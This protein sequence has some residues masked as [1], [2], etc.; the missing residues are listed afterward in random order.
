MDGN[1]SDSNEEYLVQSMK[2]EIP[3]NMQILKKVKKD[4]SHI[5]ETI[6]KLQ[7]KKDF[8]KM[9]EVKQKI[10][11][12]DSIL[13]NFEELATQNKLNIVQWNALKKLCKRDKELNEIEGNLKVL[14]QYF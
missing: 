1:V 7:K 8:N 11:E 5:E 3:S 14:E 13:Q 10:K 12:T 6:K 9:D 4:I 2:T